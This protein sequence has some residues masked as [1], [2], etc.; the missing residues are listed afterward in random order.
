VTTTQDE[1]LSGLPANRI[2]ALSD[3]IFAIAMTILV[4]ELHVPTLDDP[5]RLGDALA[6]IWPK[7]AGYVVSFVIIGTLWVGHH[8]QFHYIRRMDRT[9]LWLNLLFL[10]CVSFLPFCTALVGSYSSEALAIQLYGGTLLVAGVTLL[11]HWVYATR[12]HRLTSAT[13]D[14]AVVRSIRNRILAGMCAYAT[15][16][17]ASFVSPRA[18]LILYAAMPLLYLVPTRVDRRIA[19]RGAGSPR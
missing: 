1:G 3:G 6:Q 14:D 11:A 16:F 13:L 18:S 2:E 19:G 8:F 7:I 5:G 15:A 9:L 10:M 17:L 4:L 12:G